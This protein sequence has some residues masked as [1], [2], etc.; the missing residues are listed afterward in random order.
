MI[1]TQDLRDVSEAAARV[2]WEPVL[3]A[4]RKPQSS[5]PTGWG[6][7]GHKLALTFLHRPQGENSGT[8]YP[9]WRVIATCV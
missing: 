7:A 1:G 5:A 3:P 4:D 6:Q 8:A 9:L 2:P